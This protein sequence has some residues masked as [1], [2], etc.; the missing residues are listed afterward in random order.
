MALP[1][2]T[3]T[4]CQA[5]SRVLTSLEERASALF[6]DTD[7]A[8]Y[9]IIGHWA[10]AAL[11][12]D[13]LRETVQA[14]QD[15]FCLSP[16]APQFAGNHQRWL[17]A[18]AELLEHGGADVPAFAEGLWRASLFRI[19]SAVENLWSQYPLLQRRVL[20]E[21]DQTLPRSWGDWILPMTAFM[22][23]V[24]T[25][26]LEANP[27]Y[28]DL[29]R[30]ETVMDLLEDRQP[31][32]AQTIPFPD[33]SFTNEQFTTAA[34]L[35]A[36]LKATQDLVGLVDPRGYPRSAHGTIPLLDVYTPL[37]LIPLDTM[38]DGQSTIRYQTATFQI[39][40]PCTFREPLLLRETLSQ[41]GVLIQ[42]AVAQ[43]QQVVILGDSGAGKTTLVRYLAADQIRFLL[44]PESNAI[45]VEGY[46]DGVARIRV[47]RRVPIYVDMATFVD[48]RHA[49]ETLHEFILR[50]AADRVHD[51]SV[52]RVL[53]DLL[54]SGQ[55]L[56]LLDGLDQVATD[57]QRRMLSAA[58]IQS[59]ARWRTAGNHIVV[60][61]R[62]EGYAS[63]P[64]P[65]SFRGF[66]IRNLD[67][68]Q[69]GPFLLRWAL[70]LARLRRPL[71]SDDE[72][73]RRAE[74]ETLSL[75]RE[76]ATNPRLFNLVNT[77]LILRML[78]GVYRPGML[79]T[80][81][82]AA[83]Y[84]L[85]A[86]AMI[87]EWR[88]P[89]IATE[90]PAVLEQDITELLGELAFW[91]QS[92]RPAGLLTEHELREILGH[93]WSGMRPAA[94][95][96][97]VEEAIDGFL[98]YVRM[99]N[100]VLAELAPQRYGFIYHTLQE[101]F[102]AR[103]LVSSYR[104]AS[105]RIRS[106]LHDPRWDEVIRLAVSFTSLR[107]R[108]DAS[109]LIASAILGKTPRGDSQQMP[110]GPFE[111]LLHRDLFFAA[112]LLG[113]GI[114]AGPEVT[115]E[116]AR[117]LMELWLDGDRDSTGRFTLIF[118]RARQHLILLDGTSASWQA[119]QIARRN[120]AHPDEHRRAFAAEALVFWPSHL[121]DGCDALVQSGR[122]APLL[123]RRAIAGA[124]GRVGTLTA[125]A[126]RLLLNF[127]SDADDQISQLA[128][129]ALEAAA[130]VPNEALSMWIEFLRSGNPTRRRISLRVLGRMGT[131]PPMVINELLHLLGDPDPDTRQAA[132]D[133]LAGVSV[134]HENAL[135]AICRAAMDLRADTDIR[136]AAINALRRPV[137]LPLEVVDLLV[138]WTHDPDVA[139]RRSAALALGTCLNT[140]PD[141]IDALIELLNDPVDS[142]R[143]AVVGPLAARGRDNPRVQHVLAHAVSD[144]I[145]SV[146]CAVATALREFTV[147]SD[148][149]RRALLTLLSDREIIVREA[150]LATIAHLEQP[151]ADIIDYLVSLV[152]VQEY[153]IGAHAVEALGALRSLPEAAL[154]ALV[155][156]LRLH[157]QTAGSLIADCLKAHQPLSQDLLHQIMDL[158][159]LLP[160]GRTAAGRAPT[161][162][163]AIALEILGASLD[164]AP[165]MIRVLVDAAKQADSLQ[166]QVAALRGLALS[167]SM[168]AGIREDLM[169]LLN[170]GPLEVR[171]AAGVTLGNLVRNL[172]DPPFSGEEMLDLAGMLARLL[173][174][175]SPRASWESET[176]LQNELLL[177]LEWVVARAR[178]G[179]PRL[180]A[181]LEDLTG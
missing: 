32:H 64:L 89:Q 39:S 98:H 113:R 125:A 28:E 59:A 146:R 20:A 106:Y 126:Y 6:E 115:D 65:A 139:V 8:V 75:V 26:L 144:P 70:T 62:F 108:E 158:A 176:R 37:R 157:W 140:I 16:P 33:V 119:L 77:P 91:L 181:H 105:E 114:E 38:D 156:A 118:E 3:S 101:Y 109:D 73:R 72:A 162:L 142:V 138:D 152:N 17:E 74:T 171:C 86:D 153:G 56:L 136:I 174:E 55:C 177:A 9:H 60:T 34:A 68:S 137:E 127:V 44:D 84:Q 173:G 18:F 24:E 112:H 129:R 79:M 107:S 102:A 160:V 145:Y 27:V 46:V 13:L 122:D 111:D 54:A 169:R 2:I 80:P 48:N 151:G 7:D 52:M 43:H 164:E 117:D 41:P 147:P 85:V 81:Q 82:R 167:H 5:A 93:I 103:Y 19:G 90:R 50:D 87:H 99:N 40:D 12:L 141:V 130:P 95:P 104:L 35:D 163:R 88:L 14:A 110:P 166:V 45:Q 178:P 49:E 92:S 121:A 42:D 36:Y 175:I 180:A 172:P 168:P 4:L 134:L 100:G 30:S 161:G 143:A 150:T 154:S 116:V 132:V 57:D 31:T 29:L 155:G 22:G 159:V 25:R 123:V 69:I 53:A 135:M 11:D 51:S 149:L 120:L 128:Q 148:E 76:V 133:V 58:V 23:I 94:R 83:I 61:S 78:V 124:L 97:Q 66:V 10:R 1:V 170:S 179:A 47:S 131:L 96:A 63:A 165:T 15:E 67:R 71:I 21:T